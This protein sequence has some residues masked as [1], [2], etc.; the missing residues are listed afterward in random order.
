MGR[1]LVYLLQ[2]G[3][4]KRR[5][6]NPAPPF[7]APPSDHLSSPVGTQP[8]SEHRSQSDMEDLIRGVT[9]MKETTILCFHLQRRQIHKSV[10]RIR[11]IFQVLAELVTAVNE[12]TLKSYAREGPL[13]NLGTS[14]IEITIVGTRSPETREEISSADGISVYG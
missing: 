8:L 10:Q 13:P 14:L 2:K 1:L 3:I 5:P 7:S 11:T 9:S 4:S 12:T 6:S